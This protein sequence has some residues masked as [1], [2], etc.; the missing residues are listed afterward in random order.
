MAPEPLDCL[1]VTFR[2]PAV[3]VVLGS[4]ADD[5][6]A[7][8]AELLKSR[9]QRECMRRRYILICSAVHDENR[10]VELPR[11]ARWASWTRVNEG[12]I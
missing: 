4:R 8:L 5:Q 7:C 12:S 6:L 10:R 1:C 3:Q 9:G 2:Q 11:T